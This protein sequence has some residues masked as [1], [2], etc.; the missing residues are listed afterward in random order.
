MPST[1]IEAVSNPSS[2]RQTILGARGMR[3]RVAPPGEGSQSG[4]PVLLC[5]ALKEGQH[6]AQVFQAESAKYQSASMLI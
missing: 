3:H 2:A 1:Q 6:S 5:Q 4:P